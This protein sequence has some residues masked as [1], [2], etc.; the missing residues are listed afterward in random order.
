MMNMGR[1]RGIFGVPDGMD[2]PAVLPPM[3]QVPTTAGGMFGNP[4]PSPEPARK[5]GLGTRLLGQG[6]EGKLAAL[7]GAISGNPWAIPQYMQGQDQMR[8]QA[9]ERAASLRAQAERMAAAQRLGYTPDQVAILGGK[10]GE[11][12][13]DRMKPQDD[14][15]P[16]S[17]EWYQTATPEQRAQYD[18]YNPVT[19]TTWQGPS[20]IPRSSLGGTPTAPVGK[21][22]PIGPTIESTPAPQLNANG[23]PSVLSRAQYEAVLQRMGQAET[24]AWARRNNIRV[25]D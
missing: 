13:A 19:V 25:V 21:L 1:R 8:Q 15:K 10:I 4:M 9:E 14:P 6:W 22:T 24:E 3:S 23:M 2:M 11:V 12:Q 20:I 18:A 17:F 16:G 5:P 7:G